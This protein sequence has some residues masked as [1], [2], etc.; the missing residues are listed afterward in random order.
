MQKN[1]TKTVRYI[2]FF[3][4][5]DMTRYCESCSIDGCCYKRKYPY[6]C[7]QIQVANEDRIADVTENKGAGL[8][9]ACH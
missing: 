8:N 1:T 4:T 5:L 7:K 9:R 3:F 2:I 6:V